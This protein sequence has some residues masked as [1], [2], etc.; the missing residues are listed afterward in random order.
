MVLSHSYT[1]S[2]NIPRNMS[3]HL[4]LHGIGYVTIL[5]ASAAKATSGINQVSCR[6]EASGYPQAGD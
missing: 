3:D 1:W 2:G 4:P 6:A 5:R